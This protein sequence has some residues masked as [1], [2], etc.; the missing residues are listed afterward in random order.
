MSVCRRQVFD[1]DGRFLRNIEQGLVFSKSNAHEPVQCSVGRLQACHLAIDRDDNLLVAGLHDRGAQVFDL[2][3]FV[4]TWFPILIEK[5]ASRRWQSYVE[6]CCI[7]DD[8]RIW[9]VDSDDLF[10]VYAFEW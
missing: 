9:F 8:G 4:V 10:H 6:N 2:D 3:G 1:A 5:N 7:D